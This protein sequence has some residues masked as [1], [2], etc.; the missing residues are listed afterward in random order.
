MVNVRMEVM[1]TRNSVESLQ[2]QNVYL[3]QSELLLLEYWLLFTGKRYHNANA[4][5]FMKMRA[6]IEV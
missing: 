6:K 1:L 4:D 5:A 3:Y 2:Y